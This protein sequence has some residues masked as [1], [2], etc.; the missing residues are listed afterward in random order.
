[1]T[2]Q[3]H[4]CEKGLRSVL[5]FYFIIRN[6]NLGVEKSAGSASCIPSG[7][8]SQCMVRSTEKANKF[9]KRLFQPIEA[10]NH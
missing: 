4:G 6:R 7:K 9:L 5:N 2:K 1:M 8:V 3:I 10:I